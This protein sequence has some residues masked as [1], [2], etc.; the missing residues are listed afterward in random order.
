MNCEIFY[1]VKTPSNFHVSKNNDIPR[2][3]AGAIHV[4]KFRTQNWKYKNIY[5]LKIVPSFDF[6]ITVFLWWFFILDFFL[7]IIEIHRR[8]SRATEWN[9]VME[10]LVENLTFSLCMLILFANRLIH[11]A[12]EKKSVSNDI[13]I[14]S[15]RE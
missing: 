8:S 11:I 5:L 6:C 10:Q 15:N 4:N 9:F 12:Y 2:K 13:H 3:L 7:F 1:M 14:F